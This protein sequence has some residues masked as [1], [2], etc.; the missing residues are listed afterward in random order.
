M[1]L[2]LLVI[3]GVQRQCEFGSGFRASLKNSTLNLAGV[4]FPNSTEYSGHFALPGCECYG[5]LLYSTST[6]AREEASYRKGGLELCFDSVLIWLPRV[7][8]QF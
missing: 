4:S 6:N 1:E 5:N 2:G 3:R 8:I 7:V